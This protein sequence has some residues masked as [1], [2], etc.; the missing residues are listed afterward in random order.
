VDDPGL[1]LAVCASLISSYEDTPVSEQICF[2][3]EVGLGGEI[4]AVSRIENRIAEAE[5]LG[6]K[7]IMV[8]KYA[9]KGMDL[10]KFKIQII[11]VSKLEEMYQLIF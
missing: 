3:G 7:K 1:D 4:R 8:S 2:A 5:K 6:F 9:V 11:Q 10:S